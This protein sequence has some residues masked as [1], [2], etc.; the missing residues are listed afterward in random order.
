MA[1]FG[2]YGDLHVTLHDDHVATAE[3]RRPPNNFFDLALIDSL[4]QAFGD[5]DEEENCR[6]I[7]LCAEG[8]NFCAGAQ[9]GN[10]GRRGGEIVATN[11]D[12]SLMFAALRSAKQ[13]VTYSVDKSSGQ[14]TTIGGVH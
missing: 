9:F 8:K 7:V 5:L 11:P 3:I 4:V 2:I 6:A 10:D 12:G 14:L 1:E 13:L